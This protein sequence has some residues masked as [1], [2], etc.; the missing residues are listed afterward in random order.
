M[1]QQRLHLPASPGLQVWLPKPPESCTLLQSFALT[2]MDLD[3]DTHWRALAALSPPQLQAGPD[4]QQL[5]PMPQQQQPRSQGRGKAN[6]PPQPAATAATTSS[7]RTPGAPARPPQTPPASAALPLEI[8]PPAQTPQG[9]P[10]AAL[11]WGCGPCCCMFYLPLLRGCT[12]CLGQLCLFDS[13]KSHSPTCKLDVQTRVAQSKTC[14]FSST[15]CL[16]ER[17]PTLLSTP[18][19]QS[20]ECQA[21]CPMSAMLGH[22]CSSQCVAMPAHARTCTQV[23]THACMCAHET[24]CGRLQNGVFYLCLL[25]RRCPRHPCA[26][27]CHSPCGAPRP[28]ARAPLHAPSVPTAPRPASRSP[29][30]PSAAAACF[31][32]RTLGSQRWL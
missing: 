24:G 18:F 3:L 8:T 15:T 2:K 7:P 10:A 29:I 9:A 21:A 28:H 12:C 32:H 6:Q 20:R 14:G 16:L 11:L 5:P 31:E 4:A 30:H 13:M 1:W 17:L 23:H 25:R 27:A 22:S 19:T 26:R